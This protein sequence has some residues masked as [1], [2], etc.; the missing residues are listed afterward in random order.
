MRHAGDD[1]GTIKVLLD[2]FNHQRLPRALA[3]KQ[4]VDQGERLSDQDIDYL[5][6]IFQ[7]ALEMR[8]LA[9]R[10]PEYE[11]LVAKI[12]AMYKHIVDKGL[13]NERL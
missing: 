13:D 7:E 10:H 9:E 12:T 11:S 1:A 6:H 2:R 5:E 3:L 4:R 8:P